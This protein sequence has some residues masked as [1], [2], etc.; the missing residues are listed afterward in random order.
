MTVFH[1]NLFDDAF[2]HDCEG[3]EMAD[4]QAATAYAVLGARQMIAETIFAGDIV[5]ENHRIEI[6]DDA[7]R[8][9]RTVRF[10]DTFCTAP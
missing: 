7:G 3:I 1:L 5:R 2:V 4:L 8:L 10:G 9:L 6:A